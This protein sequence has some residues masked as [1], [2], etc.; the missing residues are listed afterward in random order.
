MYF[1]WF[2]ILVQNTIWHTNAVSMWRCYRILNVCVCVYLFAFRRF[3]FRLI[4]TRCLFLFRYS[5]HIDEFMMKFHRVRFLIDCDSGKY[6]I[7]DISFHSRCFSSA[8]RTK[9]FIW[10]VDL[11]PVACS[12]E[13]N[14]F[15]IQTR[16]CCKNSNQFSAIWVERDA[17]FERNSKYQTFH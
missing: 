14:F 1:R 8:W 9:H 3:S 12:K 11:D 7:S 5:N 13:N 10:C 4:C 6:Y 2:N 15:P 17:K 16:P